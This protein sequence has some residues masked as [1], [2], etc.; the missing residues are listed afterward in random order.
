MMKE[1]LFKSGLAGPPLNA[2]PFTPYNC[3]HA[4][5]ASHARTYKHMCKP[6]YRKSYTNAETLANFVYRVSP[7]SLAQ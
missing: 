4:L 5:P 2:P 7:L 6:V 3:T 1:S